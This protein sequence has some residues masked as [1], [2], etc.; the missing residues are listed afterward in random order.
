MQHGVGG[1]ESEFLEIPR[2]VGK[3]EARDTAGTA[4]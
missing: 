3:A 2:P 4:S 1:D